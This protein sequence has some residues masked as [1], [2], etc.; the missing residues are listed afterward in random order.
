MLVASALI[1]FVELAFTVFTLLILARIVISWLNL[2]PYHPAVQFLHNATEPILAPVRRVI[3]PMGMFD[4]S[5]MVVMIG[6]LFLQRILITLIRNLF[7]Y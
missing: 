3:P 4:L 6:A 1:G 5:P 7:L 2:D